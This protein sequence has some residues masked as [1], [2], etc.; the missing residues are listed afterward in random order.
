[1]RHHDDHL[2]ASL[3]KAKEAAEAV[4]ADALLG[5]VLDLRDRVLDILGEA[6]ETGEL[7][8]TI[9]AIREARASAELLAS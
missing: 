1:M 8:A 4:E 9:A 6:E 3:V 2:P 7:R 5:Q